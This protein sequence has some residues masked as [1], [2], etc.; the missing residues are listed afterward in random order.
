MTESNIIN[1]I[2]FNLLYG[3]KQT[4]IRN[5]ISDDIIQN[6]KNTVKNIIE[7]TQTINFNNDTELYNWVNENCLFV[8]LPYKYINNSTPYYAVNQV[9]KIT[10]QHIGGIPL[11]YFN[12]NFPISNLYYQS[13]Q[14]V[15]SVIDI[16][17]FTINLN[18]TSYGNI[19][20]GGK[21][22]QIMKI[23]NSITGYPNANN[24]VINLS[25][26]N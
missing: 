6:V 14:I 20:G 26:N 23:I 9:F 11:G 12:S 8:K 16:N 19:M 15:T 4:F 7:T 17:T 24:Y 22:I 25:K 1:N 10:Y 2:P 18:Y 21:N 5:D 13:N 3:Y